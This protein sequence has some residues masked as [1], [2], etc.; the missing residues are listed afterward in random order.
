[1]KKIISLLMV[2]FLL[3]ATILPGTTKA[4]TNIPVEN[5]NNVENIEINILEVAENISTLEIINE[6]GR[7]ISTINHEDQ[8]FTMTNENGETTYHEVEDYVEDVTPEEEAR[9]YEKIEANKF[10]GV[11][12]PSILIDSPDTSTPSISTF[13]YNSRDTFYGDI[14]VALGMSNASW[15]HVATYS[16]GGESVQVIKGVQ[17]EAETTLKKLTFEAGKQVASIAVAFIAFATSNGK[18]YQA[19]LQ[20]LIE[21]VADVSLGLLLTD[22]TIFFQGRKVTTGRAFNIVGEGISLT[23]KKYEFY[24]LIQTNTNSGTDVYSSGGYAFFYNDYSNVY[25]IIKM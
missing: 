14:T 11:S 22:Q 19:R 21:K 18:N 9:F 16:R 5:S 25:G 7:F 4:A 12:D 24:H 1:M 13:N 8:S 20:K 6:E 15:S 17:D 23:T 3:S 2:V 10:E